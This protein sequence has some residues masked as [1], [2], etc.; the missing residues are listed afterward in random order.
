MC[1]SLVAVR[2]AGNVI[3]AILIVGWLTPERRALATYRAG[4]N[5]RLQPEPNRIGSGL[6]SG[7]RARPALPGHV[8]LSLP[9]EKPTRFFPL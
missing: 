7:T 9:A 3:G 1:R 2:H 5:P 6:T 4:G 8:P